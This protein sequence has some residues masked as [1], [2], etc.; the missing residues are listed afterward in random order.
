[1][2]SRIRA[3]TLIE[4]LVV[5]A[6]I[7]ILA[8]ILFPVFAKAR[9]RA[10]A[11]AC[12]SNEQ[13][14]G[15]ALMMY[16]DDYDSTYPPNRWQPAFQPGKVWKDALIGYI[17]KI[18][19]LKKG[20]SSVYT[21][22]ASPAAWEP[23]NAGENAP[24]ATVTNGKVLGDETG[25]W[26]RGYAYNGDAFWGDYT[27]LNIKK[28][29]SIKSPASIIF[30]VESRLGAPDINTW[31]IGTANWQYWRNDPKTQKGWYQTH[32]KGVNFV[33]CDGHAK[34]YRMQ[35]TFSPAQ[36]WDPASTADQAHYNS[37]TA[38][39]APEYK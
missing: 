11:T 2:K 18:S 30:I 16:V 38:M 22:P 25:R 23:M 31:M 15:R 5:I 3:F 36:M 17:D 13:Q 19:S 26:P 8:A 20:S 37:L 14:I 1:M 28:V 4:L 6:I 24:Q 12:L 27:N 39:L 21:C 29:S 35:Q 7:A 10:N 32:S 33:F 34:W 9:D